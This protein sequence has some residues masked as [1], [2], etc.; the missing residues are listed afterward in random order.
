MLIVVDDDFMQARW[1]PCVHILVSLD[2]TINA[3]PNTVLLSFA[4]S[5]LDRVAY[6]CMFQICKYL[7]QELLYAHEHETQAYA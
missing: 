4:A 3:Y 7:V 2:S 1:Y 6:G 5:P